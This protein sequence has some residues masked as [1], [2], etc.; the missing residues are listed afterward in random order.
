[1]EVI[2]KED[3]DYIFVVTMGDS[4]KA[5]KNLREYRKNPHGVN[6]Q[7]LKTI[8][9]LYYLRTFHYKPNARWGRKL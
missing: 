6:Y 9:I 4:D 2:I 3:P 8:D 7:Q 5:L 1:M